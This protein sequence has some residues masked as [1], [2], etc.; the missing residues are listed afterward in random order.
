[1]ITGGGQTMKTIPAV[2]LMLFLAGCAQPYWA[3][4]VRDAADIFT[5]A[6]G[7]GAGASV[8]MGPVAAGLTESADLAGLRGGRFARFALKK[9]EAMEVKILCFGFE[10]LAKK[11]DPRGK[12][13][14][15]TTGLVV[16][17]PP[18]RQR[19]LYL[20]FISLPCRGPAT[21]PRLH[22]AGLAQIEV[23]AACLLGLRLG[24]NPGEALDFLLGWGN[25]DYLEDDLA[26]PPTAPESHLL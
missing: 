14:V 23:Q 26:G 5:V 16:Q 13:Y 3:N 1:M 21:A 6:A 19:N 7:V 24:F 20:P 9:E 11:P 17:G 12:N 10:W 18:G 8:R 25:F 2:L 4:R 22:R 15:A